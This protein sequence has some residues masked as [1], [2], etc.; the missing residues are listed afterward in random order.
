MMWLG[1]IGG[2]VVGGLL[3]NLEGAIVLGFLGWLAGLIIKSNRAALGPAATPMPPGT[4]TGQV[5]GT[6]VGQVTAADHANWTL[7]DRVA[8]LERRVVDLEKRLAGSRPTLEREQAVAT[9]PPVPEPEAAPASTVAAEVSAAELEQQAMASQPESPPPRVAPPIP[10]E[11]AAP[12]PI[13]AWLTGGNTIARVGLLILFIGLAFLLKYAADQRLLPPELR[14]AA[15]AAGGIALLAIGWRLRLRNPGY[16]LGMQGA[17]VAVLY[18]TTFGALKLYHLIPPELAFFVL[19]GIAVFS[20][21]L[22]VRQD[23][24]ALAVIGAGGGFLAPILAST[25]HGSHVLLFSY[26]LVLNA[27]ILVIAWF[28][29]WRA[30]NLTGFAFTFAIFWIWVHRSYLPE[31]YETTQPFL[32]AFF[33][34][35]VALAVLVT[36]DKTPGATGDAE[37][38]CPAPVPSTCPVPV[39]GSLVFGVPLAAFALQAKITQGMEYG[40]AI[41]AL[42]TAAFYV[43]LAWWLL[44]TK[45]ESWRLLAQAFVALAVVFVTLAIPL[46]L[47][48]RWTSAS[49]ALEGA[50]II[51]IGMRQQRTIARAFGLLLQLLAGAAYLGAG[52][53]HGTY[54]MVDAPF[55]GAIILSLAG[56]WTHRLLLNHRETATKAE[57]LLIVPFFAWGL[58]WLIGAGI[59]EIDAHVPRELRA[60]AGIVFLVVIGNLFGALARRWQWREAAFT[61]R[62]LIPALWLA[63]IYVVMNKPHPFADLGWIAW[64]LAFG[65]AAWTLR[66]VDEDDKRAYT[67]FLHTAAILLVAFLGALELNWLAAQYTAHG[68]AW[69]A[70]A[71]AFIPSLVL[72]VIAL[73]AFDNR[74]PI[75]DH[76]RA[77]RQHA[78]EAIGLWLVAWSLFANATHDARSDPLPY[79]PVINALDLAHVFAILALAMAW[80]AGQR[81]QVTPFKGLGRTGG[82]TLACAIGFIW[83]TAILLRTVSHWGD[84]PYVQAV[85]M[86]SVLVQASLSIFWAVL[87]L[88]AMVYATRTARRAIWIAGA[89][90]M[91]VVVAK[92]FLVDLGSVGTIAR[93]VSFIAVG[94]LML[95]IGYFSPV[96]P[97]KPENP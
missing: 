78:V 17:G 11:P 61:A 20:A 69:S 35:Y 31:S 51:W 43:V 80:R 44:K 66:N 39:P 62:A 40:V 88:A 41:S 22:A 46:A 71:A 15:V 87:A 47:D 8:W 53:V 13:V 70:G 68:T 79:M 36:R 90:L 56:L 57:Q 3:W 6:G 63:A 37:I 89:V 73:E 72:I 49:W 1:L 25:G 82:T 67:T 4:G 34:M 24:V 84:V 96:P 97:R 18:L 16:A 74:W 19:A 77:Y 75:G 45:R 59:D 94:V 50:A 54:P 10:P 92:L 27:G 83:L 76:P 5:L 91:G 2:I 81:S 12:N 9:P 32:I 93:I 30:L 7:E 42:V 26:Y 60:A 52:Q 48:A 28:R 29:A 95:V 14:L 85:M 38:T 65:A 23:A 21:I 86:K 33:L 64:L 58:A 55:V